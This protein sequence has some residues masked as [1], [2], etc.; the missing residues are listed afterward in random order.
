M[1]YVLYAEQD[2]EAVGILDT[3]EACDRYRRSDV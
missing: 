1:E 3:A 2:D